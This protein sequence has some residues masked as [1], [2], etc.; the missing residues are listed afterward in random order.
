[1]NKTDVRVFFEKSGRAIYISHLDLLRTMQRA[2]KRSGLPVWYSEGFNPRIY[3]NFPLALSLGVSGEREPMDFCI[4]A[5]VSYEEIVSRL[6]SCMPEGL[7]IISAAAPVR[8]NK[9]IGSA[10]YIAEFIGNHD[11]ICSALDRYLAQD[12]IEVQKHSKKKGMVT[13]DIKP[14]IAVLDREMTDGGTLVQF[15][16]PAGNELNLNAGI[17]TDSFLDFCGK[18]GIDATLRCTKRT[19]I[20]CTDGCEFM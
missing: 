7:R 19:N 2:L 18:S 4:V 17:F 12:V 1:M 10:L 14:H 13:V 6:D 3:L 20:Y 8:L 16:M 11:G 9:E 5:D 15:R